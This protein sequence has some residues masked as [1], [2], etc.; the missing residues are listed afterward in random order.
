MTDPSASSLGRMLSVLD[1]FDERK[2]SVS[3]E[4]IA[5]ELD[6]SLPTGYRYVKMLVDAGLLQRAEESRY[7]LGPRVMVLDHYIRRA[8][9]VLRA[10]IATMAELVEKTGFDCVMS[11]LYGT[12][13]LDTH[14]EMG[15]NPAQLAYGRGRPRP[16]F[17]GAAPKVILAHFASPQLRRLFEQRGEEAARHGLSSEWGEFRRYFS[18]IRKAGHY[19]SVGELEPQLA[20]LAAPVLGPDGSAPAAVSLVMDVQ[21]LSVIDTGKLAQLVMQAAQRIGERLAEALAAGPQGT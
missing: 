7:T 13:V 20:A 4:E 18:A 14:R 3:P 2:L 11:G 12:Q 10:G 19:L 6:V 15:K 16:L 21:R 5:A 1:L 9:P 8:D 17:Q